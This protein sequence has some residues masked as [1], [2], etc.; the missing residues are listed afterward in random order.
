MLRSPSLR[1]AVA[2]HMRA[3]IP[4]RNLSGV[5]IAPGIPPASQTTRI[6]ETYMSFSMPDAAPPQV[7]PQAQIVRGT[8]Q[9]GASFISSDLP[10]V[11]DFWD[12]A[13][14]RSPQL[15][16]EPTLPKISVISDTDHSHNL[17]DANVSPDGVDTAHALPESSS[18]GLRSFG[19][20]GILDDLS[21]DLGL[22]SAK[23]IKTGVFNLLRSFR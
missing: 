6:P 20:G 3:S 7:E 1:A 10:Y 22:P 13:G 18:E 8:T 19:K 23:E 16:A 14:K 21:E 11:P 5:G 4:A 9:G 2:S 12:S 17:H 15:Q